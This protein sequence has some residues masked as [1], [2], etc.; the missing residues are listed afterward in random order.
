MLRGGGQVSGNVTNTSGTV[1]PGAS[2]GTLTVTGSYTQGAAGVLEIDI[3]GSGHDQL[4][5]GGAATLDGTLAAVPATGFDPAPAAAFPVPD[6]RLAQRRVRDADGHAAA[7]ATS[8][9][10]SS[11]RARRTSARG[12][13]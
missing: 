3:D 13:S 2:P 10:G 4:A 9:S 12:W 8:G 1:R 5:V 7:R 11:T 6:L